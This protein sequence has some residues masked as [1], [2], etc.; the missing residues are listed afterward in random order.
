M[1]TNKQN[2]AV[3]GFKKDT[4]SNETLETGTK[5]ISPLSEQRYVCKFSS[6]VFR[7]ISRVFCKAERNLYLSSDSES[8]GDVE[9]FTSGKTGFA[10]VASFIAHTESLV[11]PEED[12]Q[13]SARTSPSQKS[14]SDSETEV[15]NPVTVENPLKQL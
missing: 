13:L 2:D 7:R 12:R 15:E 6:I 11:L 1:Y 8:E 10:T 14:N 3:C 4:S 9:V 5:N